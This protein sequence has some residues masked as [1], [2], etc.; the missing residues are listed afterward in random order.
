MVS[1]KKRMEKKLLKTNQ[2]LNYKQ[3]EAQ[4]VFLSVASLIICLAYKK[5]KKINK[6]LQLLRKESSASH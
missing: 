5:K 6:Y 1:E 2:Q 4:K 3:K